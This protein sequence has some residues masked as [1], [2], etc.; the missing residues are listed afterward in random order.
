MDNFI[1]VFHSETFTGSILDSL[2]L[3]GATATIVTAFS[4]VA[5]WCVGRR[6]AGAA[7]I[8][9][10]AATPL[11]F[12]SIVLGIAFLEI[13]VHFGS[14]YG[15]LLSLVI[16]SSIAY[17]P[18]GLRYAQLGVLQIHPELEEAASICG[19]SSLGIFRRIILPLIAPSLISCWLFV[20]LLAVRAV[21]MILLLAGPNSH[22]VAVSL[23]DLWNDGQIGELA[24]IGCVWTG[25]VT[26]FSVAFYFT[27]KRYQ[28]PLG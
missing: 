16:V 3:G 28:L 18:Y 4:S 27:A 15:S 14:L 22:V 25:I 8:D 2:I 1:E 21:S 23:F 10:L 9:A 24:A 19:A 5:G 20:F 17:V 11:I 12:P 13:V 6:V 26:L 7:I